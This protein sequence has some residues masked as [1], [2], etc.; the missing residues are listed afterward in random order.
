M[1]GLADWAF[2]GAVRTIGIFRKKAVT[3]TAQAAATDHAGRHD[4]MPTSHLRPLRPQCAASS[5]WSKPGVASGARHS[6]KR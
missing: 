5:L 4:Q 3:K 2:A 6:S 1:R